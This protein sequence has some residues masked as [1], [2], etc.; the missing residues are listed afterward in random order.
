MT[1][2]QRRP[3]ARVALA[4][5]A[6][7]APV[8]TLSAAPASP[9]LFPA[10]T[11]LWFSLPDAPRFQER[12]RETQIGLLMQEELLQPFIEQLRA[13][14]LER[15]ATTRRLGVTIEDVLSAA[16]GELAMGVAHRE[17]QRAA[18]IA[19]VDT[20]GKDAEA[21]ALVEKLDAE[22][23][24][25]GAT[26]ST[27]QIAGVAA[28]VYLLPQREDE[29]HRAEVVRF[30]SGELL[31]LTEGAQQAEAL[32][33]NIAGRG[34][35]T[36]QGVKEFQTPMSRCADRAVGPADV[37]WWVDPFGL[38]RA[39]RSRELVSNLPD[40][41]DTMT[42]LREQGFDAIRAMGGH[43]SVAVD[44]VKDF[45]HQTCVYA[46]PKPGMAG[47]PAAE[48]WDLGMRMAETP[49]RSDM[50][51]EPWAPRETANYATYSLDVANAF[52]H[53][54]SVFDALA[55][56]ENAFEN[57]LQG[58]EKDYFGPRIKV[59]E[60]LI[61]HLDDRITV[62]A[63]YTLPITTDCERYLF[64]IDAKNP[65]KLQTPV[66]KLMKNEGAVLKEVRGVKYWE[67]VP[68]EVVDTSAELGGLVPIDY[69]PSDPQE[70]AL[71]RRAAVCLH[72]GR[73]IVASDVE[74]LEQALF[75]V[76]SEDSLAGS[77]DF[78]AAT[79]ELNALAPTQRAGWSFDRT[80]ETIRPTYELL[81]QGRLPE[82]QTFFARLL[83]ELLTTPEDEEQRVLRKQRIDGSTL[84]SFELVRRYFGPSARALVAEDDGWFVTGVVLSKAGQ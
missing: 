7:F 74:Y 24:E 79:R 47:R 64:V 27:R 1:H 14:T 15:M 35:G 67:T 31:C 17:G 8:A 39:R 61:A 52:D 71:L 21:Q 69:Q 10:D 46:P 12:L 55:G 57:T 53:V 4:V 37:R 13:Q 16:G 83:N 28:V 84:P 11:V 59:R 77:Y 70:E 60:E 72:K 26:R 36:L 29:A 6:L 41:K 23:A 81:R 33:A 62:M 66:D 40:R 18:T 44:E 2:A 75:G 42:I 54:E 73:L 45:V 80:D 68:E 43:V 32:L 51:V 48:K 38:D 63:D 82:G 76:P 78:Q 50:S 19:L 22:M 5:A 34:G 58:F 30:R 65:A 25:R 3:L 56:Y 49:N 20:T 9:T